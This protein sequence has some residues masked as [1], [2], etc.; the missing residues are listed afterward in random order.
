MG[1]TVGSGD[2]RIYS[3]AEV[4]RVLARLYGRMQD[5]QWFDDGF[6]AADAVL[7]EFDKYG[8]PKCGELA[9][10]LESGLCC[11]GCGAFIRF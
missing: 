10:P 1:K 9:T 3:R 6:E 5:G 7:A 4:R 8:C 11:E 2:K